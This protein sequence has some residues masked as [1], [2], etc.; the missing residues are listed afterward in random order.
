L[1][2]G[3]KNGTAQDYTYIGNLN[4]KDGKFEEAE[5]N[6]DKA[7]DYFK[8]TDNKASLLQL[9]LT[10]ARMDLMLSRMDPST[11]HLPPFC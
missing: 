3:D 6:F 5:T 10:V 8:E 9:L 2:V 1:E 7:I 4:F 11:S